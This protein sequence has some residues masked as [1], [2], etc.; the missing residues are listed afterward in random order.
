MNIKICNL[1]KRYTTKKGI[2]VKALDQINLQLQGPGLIFIIGK[3]G[4]GKTTLLNLLG[5]ID[6]YDEG[7]IFINERS[8]NHFRK[9]DYDFYR[10]SMVGFVFQEYNLLDDL[11]ISDN[12]NLALN[13][14]RTKSQDEV[15]HDLLRAVDLD[16]ELAKRYPKQLSMG[17][18]QRVAIAR[19]LIKS[20]Q[21]ILADEPTGA[22]DSETRKEIYELFKKISKKR[23]VIIVTHDQE[24]AFHYGDRVIELCDGKVI[25][26]SKKGDTSQPHFQSNSTMDHSNALGLP[27]IKAFH[28]GKKNLFQS[29]IRW[30]LVLILSCISFFMMTIAY[31]ISNYDVDRIL[32]RSLYQHENNYLI[33]AD[34]DLKEG[35][36][37]FINDGDYTDFYHRFQ[38]YVFYP[39]F[40]HLYDNSFSCDNPFWDYSGQLRLITG[41]MEVDDSIV[42]TLGFQLIA[43]RLP[44]ENMEDNEIAITKFTFDLLAK[45][46]YLEGSM[47][48]NIGATITINNQPY[49]ISGII[50]T[51]FDTERYRKLKEGMDLYF[52]DGIL[53]N[54]LYHHT[55]RGLHTVVFVR[56]G[57]YQKHFSLPGRF[58]HLDPDIPFI[59][60][61]SLKNERYIRANMVETLDPNDD[62]FWFDGKER[63]ALKENEII[64]SRNEFWYK[65]IPDYETK[66]AEALRDLVY[67]YAEKTFDNIATEFRSK[68]G[69]DMKAADYAEYILNN[70]YYN[71]F[72]PEKNREYFV[73][74]AY[75]KIIAEHYFSLRD[76]VSLT[77]RRAKI[78]VK[79]VGFGTKMY[80]SEEVIETLQQQGHYSRLIVPLKTMKTDRKLIQYILTN[81]E[82]HYLI[83]NDIARTLFYLDDL[84]YDF[85][86]MFRAVVIAFLI[87]SAIILSNQIHRN[88]QHNKKQIGILRAIG[89]RLRD[90]IKIYLAETMIV[91]LSIFF[92]TLIASIGT[93]YWINFR[94]QQADVIRLQLLYFSPIDA[95]LLLTLILVIASL[96]VIMPIYRLSKW[97]PVD[98]IKHFM[99]D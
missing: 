32:L 99:E 10:L 8:M 85:S 59:M 47:E 26:D 4:S 17:Q 93:I 27:L 65:N 79:V 36:Q 98:L 5:G 46:A 28:L 62:V 76:T 71:T 77:Y 33:I 80:A 25:S 29:P 51:D 66:H 89:A 53:L 2:S 83:A 37:Y 67:D 45:C 60:H 9:K 41:G 14:Q 49:I 48:E 61:L 57:Y 38:G 88:I 35:E 31:T 70:D 90:V 7:E 24:S 86:T 87:L 55:I 20:P 94:F 13:L 30:S 68:Y 22:L 69:E 72:D 43:G 40:V 96:A 64:L 18:K 15:I 39:V 56:S 50:D 3:S 84:F 12:I 97:Q 19:A 1:T 52:E 34:V 58:I 44:Q 92:I 21:I 75:D 78:D 91:S 42:Q 95:F 82:H 16:P 81:E 73:D 11:T 23:L 54:E 63:K 6:T 74:R